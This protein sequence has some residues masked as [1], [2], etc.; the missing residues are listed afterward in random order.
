MADNVNVTPGSG[1]T[2]AA[3]DVGGVLHQRVKLVMGGEGVSEGDVASSNPMPVLET[4]AAASLMR[5]LA[6]IANPPSIDPASGRMRVLLDATG[7]AQTLGTVTTVTTVSTLTNMAQVGGIAANSFIY[8]QMHSAW[9]LT[10]RP[11]IT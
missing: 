7:G 4:D 8:D 1:A 5:L 3:D 2:I 9:A 6:L 10:V 11:R